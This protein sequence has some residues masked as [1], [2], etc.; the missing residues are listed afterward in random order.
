MAR[1]R[2]IK[3]EFFTSEDIVGMTPLARLLYVALWCEADREGR[4]AWK[5]KTFKMRYFPEDQC[6]ITALCQEV[7][8]RGLAVLYGESLAYIPTFKTHQHV[9]PRETASLLPE[10][11]VGTRKPRV[12]T[13]EGS[14]SDA[15]GGKEGEGKEGDSSEPHGSEQASGFAIPLN[16]GTEW[17]VPSGDLAEW[18]KA[19][20]AADVEQELRAMRAWALGNPTKR[21]TSRG[22]AAFAVR[23]LQKAQDT[24]SRGRGSSGGTDWTE[25]AQ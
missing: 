17:E 4:L 3:P 10:P 6:D 22:V 8:E 19:F 11:R 1:I 21:K 15:Q 9:N 14:V 25:A 2:T 13:R 18:V 20:P 16:D 7:L 12:G 5:P 24:P 23:W